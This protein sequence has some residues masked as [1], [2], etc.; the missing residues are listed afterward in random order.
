MCSSEET[1]LVSTAHG[2]ASGRGANGAVAALARVS[3]ALAAANLLAV[4]W[5]VHATVSLYALVDEHHPWLALAGVHEGALWTVAVG[6]PV[7]VYIGVKAVGR[8]WVG[9]VAVAT[10]LALT[11]YVAATVLA[12]SGTIV[13]V[14]DA[15]GRGPVLATF[16]S[17]TPPP[18][19]RGCTTCRSATTSMTSTGLSHGGWLNRASSGVDSSYAFLSK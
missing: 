13:Q 6:L 10:T 16:S 2:A 12:W 19:T 14:S 7:C 18:S 8:A 3:S 9:C 15:V 4:A 1:L 5:H 11:V 17:T